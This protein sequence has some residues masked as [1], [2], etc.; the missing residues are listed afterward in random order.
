MFL[1]WL[2]KTEED[3]INYDEL[4]ML[5]QDRPRWCQWRW[6]PAIVQNTT[7]AAYFVAMC[8]LKLYISLI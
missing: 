8:V 5:A 1:D 3:K 2:L 6:K 4:K 7:A